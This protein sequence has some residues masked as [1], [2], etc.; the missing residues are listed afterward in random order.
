M[1]RSHPDG[2]EEHEYG[3]AIP[4]GE[5]PKP[6]DVIITPG[7]YR[8]EPLV[9]G[10]EPSPLE[11]DEPEQVIPVGVL[12]PMKLHRHTQLPHVFGHHDR[13][14]EAVGQGDA[15]VYVMDDGS[16]HAMVGRA[17][18]DV[19]EG[20]VYALVGRIDR[21]RCDQLRAGRIGTEHAFDEVHELVL[22]GTEVVEEVLSS[23]VFDVDR[24]ERVSD[25]RED[26]LPPCPFLHFTGDLDIM[27]D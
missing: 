6:G 9:G 7:S 27:V 17:V 4:L 24:Y 8:A 16:H 19:P 21:D 10:E 26:F 20:V 3:E 18:G 1:E 13:L 22:C 11:E 15:T 14:R 23:V 25:V 2:D 12:L 5:R